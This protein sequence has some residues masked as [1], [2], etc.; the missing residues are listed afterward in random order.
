MLTTLEVDVSSGLAPLR[1]A[2]IRYGLLHCARRAG[3]RLG[4]QVYAFGFGHRHLRLLVSGGGIAVNQLSKALKVAASNH[5]RHLGLRWRAETT[6]NRAWYGSVLEGAAWVQRDVLGPGRRDA[7]ATP[8]TSHRDV[9]GLRRAPF[10]DPAPLRRSVDVLHLHRACSRGPV[11]APPRWMPEGMKWD[12]HGLMRV[13]AAVHGVLPSERAC[14]ATFVQ[15]SRHC[16]ASSAALADA[17]QVGKRRVRH[18]ASRRTPCVGAVL[19]SLTDARL[20]HVP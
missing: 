15:A 17:L 7:L 2:A 13:S 3:V 6:W 18:Y 9:V 8:W 12:L 20:L 19:A 1:T 10:F 11:P 4:V 14:F 5:A 16:G